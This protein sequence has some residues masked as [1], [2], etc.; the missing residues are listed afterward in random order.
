MSDY[1]KKRIDKEIESIIDKSLE[2]MLRIL[3]VNKDQLDSIS[4][5]LIN[6]KTIDETMLH[7]KIQITYEFD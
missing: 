3:E 4:E 1:T 5:L 6:Y 2:S 7:E